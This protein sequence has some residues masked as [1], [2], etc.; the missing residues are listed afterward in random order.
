MKTRCIKKLNS[1]EE[2][3]C[4]RGLGDSRTGVRA[5]FRPPYFI[6]LKYD[7]LR[8]YYRDLDRANGAL[9][10]CHFHTRT[11]RVTPCPRQS[12]LYFHSTRE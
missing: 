9:P 5:F 1:T 6:E 11:L 7:Q 10:L 4:S 12:R 2:F 3:T 8:I